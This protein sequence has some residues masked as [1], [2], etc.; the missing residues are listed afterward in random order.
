MLEVLIRLRKIAAM[1]SLNL[2][3][4]KESKS[5]YS[6]GSFLS[7]NNLFRNMK[8]L[9]AEKYL[10]VCALPETEDYIN[11]FILSR[12]SLSISPKNLWKPRVFHNFRWLEKK[13]ARNDSRMHWRLCEVYEVI[14][15]IYTFWKCIQY[16]IDWGKSQM[17]KKFSSEKINSTK[18]A[19][20]F[21]V[22][23]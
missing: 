6:N 7:L 9:T 15:F 2:S 1:N 20:F 5:S 18:N 12:R 22:F 13:M 19:L 3:F 17:F 21:I 23:F 8:K 4:G 14:F 11:L 10:I 16:I